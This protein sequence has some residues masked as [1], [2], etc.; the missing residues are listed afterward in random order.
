[1]AGMAV[2]CM[3]VTRMTMRIAMRV[4]M[5]TQATDRHPREAY[6]TKRESG[7]IYVH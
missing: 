6:A 2:T 5:A 1:M 4:S 3:A 7:E